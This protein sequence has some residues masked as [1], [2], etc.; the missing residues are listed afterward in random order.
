MLEEEESSVDGNTGKENEE[1]LSNEAKD[2]KTV[3]EEEKEATDSVR[4][5]YGKFSCIFILRL[6]FLLLTYDAC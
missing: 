2:L 1:A 3:E 6:E 5:Q 4:F